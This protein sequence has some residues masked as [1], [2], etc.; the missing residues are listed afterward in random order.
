MTDDRS[1]V[2]TDLARHAELFD[3]SG[4]L[5]DDA[6]DTA[7]EGVERFFDAQTAPDGTP[8]PALSPGY[9]NWKTKHFPGEPMGVLE[10]HLR[11]ELD[12]ERETKPHSATVTCGRSEEAIE[13]A[14]YM[15]EGD[16]EGNRP[17]RPFFGLNAESLPKSDALFDKH[18]E[19]GTR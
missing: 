10:G 18:F 6:L 13:H 14:E 12:G 5:G 1:L 4:G 19:E 9:A 3:L 2:L 16:P 11:S 17:Q 15:E 7:I 8:W